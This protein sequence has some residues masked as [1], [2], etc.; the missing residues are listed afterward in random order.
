MD[1]V[2]IDLQRTRC[3]S[4]QNG[5]LPPNAFTVLFIHI[6]PPKISKAAFENELA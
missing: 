1:I 3:F 4:V 2:V 6:A 5:S